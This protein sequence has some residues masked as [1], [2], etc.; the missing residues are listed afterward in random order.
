MFFF[1]STPPQRPLFKVRK[2]KKKKIKKC[3]GNNFILDFIIKHKFYINSPLDGLFNPDTPP[4]M[5][6]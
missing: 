5:L 3:K 4:P 1:F 6:N 2:K